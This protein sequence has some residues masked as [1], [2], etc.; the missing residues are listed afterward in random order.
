MQSRSI[1]IAFRILL[2]AFCIIIYFQL[3][4]EYNF[5]QDDSFISFRYAENFVAGN[6]LVFNAEE[7]V[8]GYT[9]FL[10]IMFLSLLK[11]LGLNLETWSQ[12]LSFIWGV[13]V[14]IITYF[15]S[16]ELIQTS[17]K[18]D[19]ID[20]LIYVLPAYLLAITG[21]FAYWSISGMETSLFILLV[22]LGFL[23]ALK[24]KTTRY[25]YAASTFL[26]LSALTRPEGLYFLMAYFLYRFYVNKNSI[27][28]NS[29]LKTELLIALIPILLHFIFRLVYYGYPLP[30]T[31]YAKAGISEFFLRR[32]YEYFFEFAKSNLLY[33]LVLITPF[34]FFFKPNTTKKI[35]WLYL[36]SAVYTLIIILIGG[37]VLPF[38]RLFLPVLPI[39]YILFIGSLAQI[40]NKLKKYSI[41]KFSLIILSLLILIIGYFNFRFEQPKLNDIHATE[42]GLVYKMKIYAEWVSDQQDL[43][44]KKA[45]VALSTI[46]AFS[47]FSDSKIIDLLGLTNEYIAHNPAEMKGIS[48]PATRNWVERTYNAEYVL[49]QKPDYIIFPAG[50]K[51]SAFPES[52]LYISPLFKELYYPQLIESENLF[53]LITVFTLRSKSSEKFVPEL[54]A[55]CEENASVNFIDATNL[56]LRYSR[57]RDEKLIPRI[58]EK[59]DS[60]IIL[61]PLNKDD[62]FELKGMLYYF[63][64][65]SARSK[66]LFQKAIEIDSMN[67]PSYLYLINIYLAQDSSETAYKYLRKLKKLSPYLYPSLTLK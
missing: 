37:D 47:Y 38:H 31:F 36:T 15:L 46:G 65:N 55:K 39:I 17:Y 60:T 4:S 13:G 25:N 18:N 42:L 14:I 35:M 23:F 45:T 21:G 3:T 20:S 50:A 10:W 41:R 48:E 52:A 12:Y 29:T 2:L 28:Q 57:T 54:P 53:E 61:C 67:S 5:V 22:L 49:S 58:L 40:I 63:N 64:G 26:M 32:G 44:N 11:V 33:G 24:D 51:P 27:K 66:S 43:F 16:K 1:K 6:G 30:N 56:F 8:E 59:A 9:S 62:I 34:I 7:K 19:F